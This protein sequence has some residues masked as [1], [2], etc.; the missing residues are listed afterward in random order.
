[1]FQK[2]DAFVS[3]DCRQR[4]SRPFKPSVHPSTA[5]I[6]E[7]VRQSHLL[8]APSPYNLLQKVTRS[9]KLLARMDF[10]SLQL[11]KP[12]PW[13]SRPYPR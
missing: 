7:L 2:N 12:I 8:F 1:M 5:L 10:Q 13:Q 4:F 9:I 3:K 6:K 11:D